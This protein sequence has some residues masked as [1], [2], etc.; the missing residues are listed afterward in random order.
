MFSIDFTRICGVF[1]LV[2]CLFSGC[3]WISR[4]SQVAPSATPVSIDEPLS[5]IPFSTKEPER[6]SAEIVVTAEGDE[7]RTLIARNGDK[8]RAEYNFGTPE[9]IATITADKV[10]RLS[11]ASK[12]F[13]EIA[14]ATGG[15]SDDWQDFLTTEWVNGTRTAKFEKLETN[16]GITRYRAVFS[17][18]SE[19]LIDVDE[20]VGLPVKQQF[21]VVSGTE[22]T[23]TYTFELK[24]FT[25]A[26]DDALFAVPKDYKKVEER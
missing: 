25:T 6:F 22:K 15:A 26:P 8:R 10:F 13:V 1:A 19:A 14:P 9:A 21:F 3:R 4:S 2:V 5:G 17:D 20:A 18:A 12:T 23:L 7:R 11:P 24:N 16:A